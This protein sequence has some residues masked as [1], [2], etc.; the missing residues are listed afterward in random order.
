M[1]KALKTRPMDDALRQE[2]KRHAERIARIE[3]I[4]RLAEQSGD[5][6]TVARA[7]KLLEQ[8]NARY[9]TYLNTRK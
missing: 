7:K 4:Q 1:D 9:S 6:A 3:R 8:E 5:T 2:I